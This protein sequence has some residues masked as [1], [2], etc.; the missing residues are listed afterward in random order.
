MQ[1]LNKKNLLG[2]VGCVL[3]GAVLFAASVLSAGAQGPLELQVEESGQGRA[4]ELAT[5][6]L[7][8]ARSGEQSLGRLRQTIEAKVPG[9]SILEDST[10]RVLVKLPRAY[11]RNLAALRSEKIDIAMPDAESSPVFYLKGAPR[12]KWSRRLGTKSVLVYLKPGETPEQ[13]RQTAGAAGVRDV[14]IQGVTVLK[15]TTAFHAVEATKK[16]AGQGVRNRPLLRQFMQKMAAP[17]QDQFFS[18]QWHLINT[19]QHNGVVGVDINVLPV[20]DFGL[21]NGITIAIVEIGRASCRERV[22]LAV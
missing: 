21:G 10:S 13:V 6:E 22:C 15:F 18:E 5:D 8:V 17:P 19:G 11:D 2:R 1:L 12:D 20:W 7:E 9:A 16:L 3:A 4:I 14:G